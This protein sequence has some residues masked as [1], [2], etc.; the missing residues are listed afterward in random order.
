MHRAL[1][2]ILAVATF[3]VLLPA[4]SSAQVG[5]VAGTVRDTSGAVM[6]GVTVEVT[7]PALIEKVRSTTTDGS[8]AVPHHQSPRRHLLRRP[9]RSKAFRSSSRT[10]S[11]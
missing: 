7:S 3:L 2:G 6:P 1:K 11:C 4:V 5:Q 8:R 9:S 10:T